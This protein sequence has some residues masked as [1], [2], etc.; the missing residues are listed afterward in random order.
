MGGVTDA[1]GVVIA[2][3]LCC[4]DECGDSGMASTPLVVSFCADVAGAAVCLATLTLVAVDK[5]TALGLVASC[6]C[7]YRWIVWVG[8]FDVMCGLIFWSV[9]V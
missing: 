2:V 9:G 8:Y 4:G 7:W 3:A 5:L 1:V 6:W